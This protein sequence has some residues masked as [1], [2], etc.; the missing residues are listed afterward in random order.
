MGGD[1][2]NAR[3]AAERRRNALNPGTGGVRIDPNPTAR[4]F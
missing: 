1:T 2:T 3:Y 4:A